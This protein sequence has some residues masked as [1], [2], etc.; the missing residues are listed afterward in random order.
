MNDFHN[1]R[2]IE[3]TNY[4]EIKRLKKLY[5]NN[6]RF[7]QF[8]LNMTIHS[9]ISAEML[10]RRF[11]TNNMSYTKRFFEVLMTFCY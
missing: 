4:H 8:R 9:R 2:L 1:L 11:D 5:S 7:Q 10:T 6:S 3:L